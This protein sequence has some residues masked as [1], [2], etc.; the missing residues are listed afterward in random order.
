V[1]KFADL[2][3]ADLRGA[4]IVGA[5]FAGCN[6]TGA[7]LR[8]AR[9]SKSRFASAELLSSKGERTGRMIPTDLSKARLAGAACDGV[10]WADAVT[11]G[12]SGLEPQQVGSP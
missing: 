8:G 12:A 3:G 1:L 5:D 4:S 2:S 11:E 7:D 6:L 9:L 10:D